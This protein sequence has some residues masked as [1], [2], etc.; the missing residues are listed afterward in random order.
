[1]LQAIGLYPE[2]CDERESQAALPCPVA[3]KGEGPGIVATECIVSPCAGADGGLP[4]ANAE[5]P[6]GAR[7]V[8]C[9]GHCGLSLVR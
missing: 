7:E 5:V 6:E 2:D 9:E 1:M 3:V 8:C 4:A